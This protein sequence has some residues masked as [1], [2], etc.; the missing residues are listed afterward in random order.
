MPNELYPANALILA[1][2][3]N[4]IELYPGYEPGPKALLDF[5]GKTALER[6]LDAICAAPELEQ[7]YIAGP[8]AEIRSAIGDE[9]GGRE[10]NLLPAGDNFAY[11]LRDALLAM[12][13][14]R[15]V[16]CAG[17]DL[18]L[19]TRDA[20]AEF[21]SLAAENKA[22]GG[23]DAYI[24]FVAR[25]HFSGIWEEEE[26]GWFYFSDG[27]YCHGNIWLLD[28]AI[29]SDTGLDEAVAKLY[30]SR[31]ESLKTAF[32]LGW[33]TAVAYILG[34]YLLK[35]HS[36]RQIAD[37]LSTDI[38]IQFVPVLSSYPGVAVDIDEAADYD[39]AQRIINSTE[40]GE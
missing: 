32:A 27:A 38:G 14:D 20:V 19:I 30:E 25:E 31:K 34:A 5:G 18:P 37:I 22:P 35:T 23:L 10:L 28:P 17:A 15:H 26:K 36:L 33:R 2:G 9:Y 29:A 1:G 40:G 24:S 11:T 13:G 39:L 6:V 21:L 4:Q 16:L 3:T 7:I 12:P 8:Q